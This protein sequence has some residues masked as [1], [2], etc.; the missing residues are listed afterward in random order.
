MSAYKRK[1]ITIGYSTHRAESIP[2]AGKL[3]ACHDT[4]ILEDPPT[5]GFEAMLISE[6]SIEQYLQYTD[7]E[8]PEFSRH[9]YFLIRKEHQKGKN[10]IQVEP[11]VETLIKIH[12]FFADGGTPDQITPGTMIFDVY[13]AEKQATEK[14]L[15][16]YKSSVKEGFEKVVTSVKNFAKADAFRF[17]L[18][19]KLRAQALEKVLLPFS[20]V[21]VEAGEIHVA[22][23]KELRTRFS[24]EVSITPQFLMESIYQQLSGKRHIYSPG[25]I[26]TLYYIFHPR[27]ET[28]LLDVLASRSLVYSKVLEKNEIT[29]SLHSNPHIRNE[30]ET[31][32]KVNLLSRDECR[33]LFSK[34]RTASSQ[35]ARKILNDYLIP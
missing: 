3:M 8:Y 5:P 35:K 24:P 34:I 33:Y 25:D 6:I 18:R 31:I 22:L 16:F 10:I 2:F 17:R 30:V 26:L 9:L 7:T 14:L 4:I 13:Q 29:G 11:Y 21:Y 12:E 20:S 19:D 15:A 28:P 1:H 23:F 32:Q 27:M